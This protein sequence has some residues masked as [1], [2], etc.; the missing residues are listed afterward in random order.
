ME[1]PAFTSFMTLIAVGQFFAFSF[2]VGR[3]RVKHNVPAPA[4]YGNPEFERTFRV[5]QNTMEQLVIFPPSLWMLGLWVNDMAAGVL[6][7]FWV[8]GRELYA[9]SYIKDPEGRGK[10]FM[11]SMAAGAILWAGALGAIAYEEVSSF[12]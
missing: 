2:L 8:I 3:A 6:A 1:L 12:F 7:I 4:T 11:I 9:M 5:Q 10:G